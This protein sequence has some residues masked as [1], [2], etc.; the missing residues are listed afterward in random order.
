MIIPFHKVRGR[1]G[2]KGNP[3]IFAALEWK[4]FCVFFYKKLVIYHS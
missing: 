2:K 3:A 4:A 1:S